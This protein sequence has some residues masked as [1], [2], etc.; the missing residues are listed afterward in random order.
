MTVWAKLDLF[1]K[2]S[3]CSAEEERGETG[4]RRCGLR[5]EQLGLEPPLHHHHHL[6][7]ISAHT[8]AVS[9]QLTQTKN[10]APSKL[11]SHWSDQASCPPSLLISDLTNQLHCKQQSFLSRGKTPHLA[12]FYSSFYIIIQFTPTQGWNISCPNICIAI[13]FQ[14]AVLETKTYFDS[15]LPL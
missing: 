10:Y 11:L 2:S 13:V 14:G 8:S 1:F 15:F 9:S 6:L 12:S 5:R 3:Q 7:I 4:L